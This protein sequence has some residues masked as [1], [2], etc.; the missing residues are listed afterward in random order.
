MSDQR[1]YVEKAGVMLELLGLPRMVGRTLG[2][3]LTA[4]AQGAS[5]AEL[6]ELLQASRASLS[7]ALRQLTLMGLIEQLPKAGGREQR[8]RVKPGCWATLTEQGNRKLETFRDLATEGLAALPPGA[9][10][11]ALREME[12]FYAVWLELFPQILDEWRR[13]QAE[14][15]R[16]EGGGT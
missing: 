3:L 7:T 4:P 6:A 14:K 1:R 5:A 9:D 12:S 2:G 13:A 15:L 8:Y 10:P 11:G 16:G